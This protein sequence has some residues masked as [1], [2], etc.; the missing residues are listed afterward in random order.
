MK[1]NFKNQRLIIS[2][3]VF[4]ALMLCAITTLFGADKKT[5][6]KALAYI[7]SVGLKSEDNPFEISH[8]KIPLEFDSVFKAYNLL[9]KQSGFDLESYCGKTL[10]RYSY[11]ISNHNM[12]P[13]SMVSANIF[14][15][16][17]EIV[18]ADLSCGGENGFITFITDSSHILQADA[19]NITSE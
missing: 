18:A 15:Y 14:F 3:A 6:E 13:E 4:F 10:A 17:G 9:Q 7:S 11:K 16:R 1:K 12:P 19:S 5:N 2:T 8:I